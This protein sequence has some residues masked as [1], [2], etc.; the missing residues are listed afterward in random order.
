MIIDHKHGLVILSAAKTASTSLHKACENLD[1]V[2][3]LNRNPVKHMDFRQFS[4]RA[5]TLGAE[6][7]KVISIIRHPY[8]KLASWYRYRSRPDLIGSPRYVGHLSFQQFIDQI[9]PPNTRAFD[10]R[11]FLSFGSRRVDCYFKYEHI[12]NFWRFLLSLNPSFPEVQRLNVGVGHKM[13]EAIMGSQITDAISWYEALP[14]I[15]PNYGEFIQ[16]LGLSE[17]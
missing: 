15:D 3:V 11:R 10:D 2:V 8:A 6:H 9:P 16:A 4:E 14:S 5:H 7:Y 12:E 17:A 1:D 13:I